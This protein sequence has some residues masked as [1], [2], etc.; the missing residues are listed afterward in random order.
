MGVGVVG[1]VG[2]ARLLPVLRT[3]SADAALAAVAAVHAAGLPVVELTT[4]IPDW[5]DV[6]RRAC[7]LD[8]LL[9]GVGTVTSGDLARTALD[10]GAAFLVSP[11]P[12]PR[13]RVVAVTA[14]V[15]F[16]EGGFTP[17]EVAAAAAFGPAKVFP[18]HVGGPAYLRSLLAVLPGAQLVPTGG[19]PLDAVR[20]YLDAGAYAVGVGSDILR[21][22][23]E[24]LADRIREAL[25]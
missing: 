12:C 4:T 17:G 22:E 18:A 24:T 16:I 8:G 9:V 19:I 5:P 13:A 1:Q 10:A 6:V 15:P 3:S 23:P 14:D 20:E 21:G 2:E 25:R 7:E 11:F